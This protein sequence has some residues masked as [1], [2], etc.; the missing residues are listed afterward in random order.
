MQMFQLIFFFFIIRCKAYQEFID[1][2][3]LKTSILSPGDSILLDIT[4]KDELH[5]FY[6]T[7][8]KCKI[9]KKSFQSLDRV[10][11]HE[12]R[13]N[14]DMFETCIDDDFPWIDLHI[15]SSSATWDMRRW[16]DLHSYRSMYQ[17]VNVK[18]VVDT[19]TTIFASLKFNQTLSS[20]ENSRLLSSWWETVLRQFS[21]VFVGSYS[22]GQ[23]QNCNY[24]SM[25]LKNRTY[26]Y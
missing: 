7:H 5:I 2:Y 4:I 23:S 19:G 17:D 20:L 22:Q 10:E 14:K 9:L 13:N 11:I 15:V 8:E 26:W 16:G 25:Y 1:F 21:F 18:H 6:A 24:N 12:R 3:Q